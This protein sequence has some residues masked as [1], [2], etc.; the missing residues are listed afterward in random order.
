MQ[1]LLTVVETASY[2]NVSR[3]TVWRWIRSKRMPAR[4]VGSRHI[5]SLA[6]AVRM[7][8]YRINIKK[9]KAGGFERR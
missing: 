4:K 1:K 7:K 5:I 2:L 8:W 9:A 6:V 3:Q